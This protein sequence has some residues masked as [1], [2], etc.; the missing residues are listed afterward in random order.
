MR[1]LILCPEYPPAEIPPGGIGTY[2][3]HI[4]HMMAEAGET[5]HVI[6]PRWDP[7]SKAMEEFCEGRLIVHRVP[8]DEPIPRARDAT[9]GMQEVSGLLQ[10]S[11]RREC[12][13]WQ[14]GLLTE[15]LVE[16]AGIDVIEAQDYD[17]PLYYFQFRRALGLGPARRPP[18]I[19]HLHAPTE[20]IAQQ[21]ESS[22]R[23]ADLAAKR[24]E[25]YSIAAA[26]AFLCP[27]HFL[28]C[29]AEVHYGIPRG[30]VA[31]IRMPLGDTPLVDR[32]DDVWRTGTISYVGR[33]EPRKG[34]IEWI[35]AAVSVA[36][37]D[38]LLEFDLI[39]ADLPYSRTLSVRQLAERLIPERLR[40]NF[41]FRG[42]VSRSD[43]FGLLS[44]ARMAVVPSRWEN[45]PNSCV[46]AMGSGL[47]V[48]ASPNGGM[49]EMI[50]DGRT[51]WIADS[52]RGRDL[53][54]ALRRAL[55]S[56]PQQLAAM[57]RQASSAIRHLCRNEDILQKHLEF[58]RNLTNRRA[59]R[60]LRLPANLPWAK[61]P[62][63]DESRPR[64]SADGATSGL[65]LVITGAAG[66]A[67][68]GEACL[69]SI[70]R[71]TRAPAAVVLVVQ[72][73]Q[74]DHATAAAARAR[75]RG[76]EVCEQPDRSPAEARNAGLDAIAAARRDPLAVVFLDVADRLDPRF[77]E[78][79][80]SVLRH[81][82]E[83]GIVS[84][85]IRSVD[86]SCVAHP[87][88]AFPYQWLANEVV[89]PMAIRMQA[90]KES[91]PFRVGLDPGLEDW[92]LANAVMVS[93]WIAVTVP[94]VLS[95]RTTADPSHLQG[96]RPLELSRHRRELLT[97]FPEM[98][99]RDLPEL[100]QLLEW[101]T[102]QPPPLT[103]PDGPPRPLRPS[104]ILLHLTLTQ[105]I[106]LVRRAFQRPRSALRY[107]LRHLRAAAKQP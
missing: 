71:Q 75:A 101:R 83:V 35:E 46:E 19:V 57:G 8:Y 81:C 79:C 1:H 84:S 30:S 49:V 68:A 107:V 69:E 96:L 20:F 22:H 100:I 103:L 64:T 13:S 27:S 65:A 63:S 89:S 70:E 76:W 39:G 11:S 47:P 77:V 21:N 29:Q 42:S 50:E 9:I 88:P 16:D 58:R 93:G 12:F 85:W 28:A 82:P 98:L 80:D 60:S 72:C 48:L 36:G 44:R 66:N 25:D 10:G 92:D 33:L 6:A 52:G 94:G 87:C 86:G 56:T 43:M 40:A 26:D 2:V 59:T 104:D 32:P 45:F 73:S 78:L 23:H 7:S 102:I 4:S 41:R 5:V 37:D 31:V 90:I 106:A 61:Q 105:Q 38:P 51:G 3:R 99:H 14:A 15:T 74:D 67:T 18:C 95:E 62:M 54:A 97:R 55:S 91:G 53:A 34:V 24:L 17:A